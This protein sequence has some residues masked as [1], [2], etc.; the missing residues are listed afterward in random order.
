MKRR[1]A[2]IL[3]TLT[4][5]GLLMADGWIG[6]KLGVG[7]STYDKDIRN[8]ESIVTNVPGSDISIDISGGGE[9]YF[10]DVF[11]IAATSLAS[12]TL[13]PGRQAREATAGP[14]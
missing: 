8:D 14:K 9:H 3:I 6:G 12:A 11:G 1:L 13:S 4:L 5:P 7:I 10:S 2:L